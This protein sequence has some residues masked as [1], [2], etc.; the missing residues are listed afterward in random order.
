MKPIKFTQEIVIKNEHLDELNHVNN[1]VY[2]S[3]LQDIAINHWYST[4]PANLRVNIRW[5]A[6]KHTIEYLKPAFLD[7]TLHI[8]TWIEHFSPISSERH[9]EIYK[10]GILLVKASTVWIALNLH[11]MKP[12]RIDPALIERFFE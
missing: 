2:F 8:T 7:D 5:V 3:F 10:N 6:R 12:T 9:Y 4:V 1:V 11:T